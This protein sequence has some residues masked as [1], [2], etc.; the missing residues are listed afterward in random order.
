MVGSAYELFAQIAKYWFIVLALFILARMVLSVKREIMIE[1]EVQREIR[2]EGTSVNATLILLSDENKKL[3]RGKLY[4]VAGETTIGKSRKCDITL[5]SANLARV[6][7]ILNMEKD[8][9]AVVPVGDA[10]VV[11]NGE[12]VEKRAMVGEGA[13]I[14]IGGLLFRLRLEEDENGSEP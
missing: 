2:Q 9:M 7:C 12:I 5:R 1:K 6:H 3:K 10:F 14:Q 13:D 8:G 11:A 4:A